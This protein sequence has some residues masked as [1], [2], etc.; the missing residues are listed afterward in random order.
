MNVS[1]LLDLW[2]AA[3]DAGVRYADV[4]TALRGAYG[5]SLTDATAEQLV[6]I[7]G[8]LQ[9]ASDSR[10][11]ALAGFAPAAVKPADTAATPVD[12]APSTAVRPSTGGLPP[13]AMIQP[14][15]VAA[16]APP[17]S[18][19]ARLPPRPF[20]SRLPARPAAPTTA[21]STLMS[22]LAGEP[23]SAAPTPRKLSDL[24]AAEPPAESADPDP[25]GSLG[26]MNTRVPPRSEILR[27][28]A[29]EAPRTAPSASTA[30]SQRPT[31]GSVRPPASAR[32]AFLNGLNRDDPDPD[33]TEEER[34]NVWAAARA[35]RVAAYSAGVTSDAPQRATRRPS[36]LPPVEVGSHPVTPAPIVPASVLPV[37]DLDAEYDDAPPQ[38]VPEL[39]D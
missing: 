18:T 6:E 26:L 9:S 21:A 10:K 31:G 4:N 39:A 38:D 29:A 25:A 32:P 2:R 34:I 24:A 3:D 23:T 7:A 27:M 12:N 33:Y 36:F 22:H 5:T 30:A 14:K 35:A 28:Q 16:T 8:R 20:G 15:P 11:Q 1:I 13:R 17:A 37:R 19:P